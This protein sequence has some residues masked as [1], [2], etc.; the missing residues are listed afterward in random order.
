M[1]VVGDKFDPWSFSEATIRVSHCTNNA[2]IKADLFCGGII[3]M[4]DL[5]KVDKATF[6]VSE[7]I[8]KYVQYGFDFVE[9]GYNINNEVLWGIDVNIERYS[10]QDVLDFIS[11]ILKHVTR[12]TKLEMAY[13]NSNG[14]ITATNFAGAYVGVMFSC[15]VEEEELGTNAFEGTLDC[16][17]VK[18][19]GCTYVNAVDVSKL[20]N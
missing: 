1:G 4:A 8:T 13:C 14:K 3:G 18:S 11:N 15:T 2:D 19:E 20:G 16:D 5:N 9:Y 10:D 6:T 12:A 7:Y 17:G